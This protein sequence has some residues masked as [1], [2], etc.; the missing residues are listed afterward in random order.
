[1]SEAVLRTMPNECPEVGLR[2][3]HTLALPACCPVSGNPH[4]GSRLTLSYRAKAAVLEVFSLR[5]YVDSYVGGRGEVRSME[6]MIQT[7]AADC[8]AVL[9]VP[10]VAVADL[11]LFP[12]QEMRLVC[13][14]RP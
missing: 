2:E 3:R 8:A 4:P 7:I 11:M 10:V 9:G 13:C 5:A 6:A 14:A 12:S 1:M